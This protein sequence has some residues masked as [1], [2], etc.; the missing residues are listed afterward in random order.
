VGQTILVGKFSLSGQVSAATF[1]EHEGDT[2]REHE[3]NGW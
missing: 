3:A 2:M 1:D